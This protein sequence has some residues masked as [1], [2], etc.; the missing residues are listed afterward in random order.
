MLLHHTALQH[1]V[2]LRGWIPTL[3]RDDAIWLCDGTAQPITPTHSVVV[4]S[5]AI[6]L[7]ARCSLYYYIHNH[8]VDIKAAVTPTATTA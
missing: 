5:R 8:M 4:H 7:Y 2:I 6:Y 3:L 1:V